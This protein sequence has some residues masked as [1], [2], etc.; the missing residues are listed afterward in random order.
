M[1]D[2]ENEEI[3]E[4]PSIFPAELTKDTPI[5]TVTKRD[6]PKL[7]MKKACKKFRV[8]LMSL[9]NVTLIP[10]REL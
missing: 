9:F 2:P 3:V 8:S 7:L 5:F 4:W 10:D 6:R 1:S